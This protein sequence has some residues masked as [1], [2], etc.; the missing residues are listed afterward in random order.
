MGGMI[1]MI[2]MVRDALPETA[3]SVA[4]CNLIVVSL[5]SNLNGLR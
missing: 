3:S 2:R 5:V 1:L 4:T